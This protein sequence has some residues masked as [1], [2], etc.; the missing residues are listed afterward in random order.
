MHECHTLSISQSCDKFQSGY[1]GVVAV[2][3]EL[4]QVNDKE[5][6]STYNKLLWYLEQTTVVKH[7]FQMKHADFCIRPAER[8]R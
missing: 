8:P 7:C 4:I 6:K 2:V 3:E 1:M 5:S